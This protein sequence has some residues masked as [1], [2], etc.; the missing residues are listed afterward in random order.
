MD[1]TYLTVQQSGTSEP[2]VVS[3]RCCHVS[4]HADDISE[5][6]GDIGGIRDWLAGCGVGACEDDGAEDWQC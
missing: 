3:S 5:A 4:G 2:R 1:G 6:R